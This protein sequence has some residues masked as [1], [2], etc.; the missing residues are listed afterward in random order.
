MEAKESGK[1]D[2]VDA[3]RNL[4]PCAFGD[5]PAPAYRRDGAGFRRR[6]LG[7]RADQRK[8]A[9]RERAGAK[10]YQ[11]DGDQLSPAGGTVRLFVHV[12][13]NRKGKFVPTYIGA[14]FAF[15]H[16]VECDEGTYPATRIFGTQSDIKVDS[17]GKFNYNL[18]GLVANF[19]GKI[20][21]QGKAA[22]GTVSYGPNDI[23][24]EDS[25][26]TYHNCALP[27]PVKYV[28]SFTKVS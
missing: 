9:G 7:R 8:F 23:F 27:N 18:K 11:L 28:A 3:P 15:G 2:G 4:G 26:L 5:S 16:T 22:A 14:M 24:D 1:A 10:T 20:T 25:G 12:K 13:K 6:P 17:K 21:K 19:A